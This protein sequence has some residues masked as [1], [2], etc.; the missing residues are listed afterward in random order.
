MLR[1]L[2]IGKKAFPAF[3]FVL[4]GFDHPASRTLTLLPCCAADPHLKFCWNFERDGFQHLS[5]CERR[6]ASR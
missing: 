6:R 4:D 5:P 2:Y 3:D 1:L